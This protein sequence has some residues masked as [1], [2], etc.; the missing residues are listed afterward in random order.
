MFSRLTINA[1]SRISAPG[2]ESGGL[3]VV[4]AQ[5]GTFRI[6]ASA[7]L[8]PTF[9][10]VVDNGVIGCAD[11]E[12]PATEQTHTAAALLRRSEGALGFS[13]LFFAASCR[14]GWLATPARRLATSWSASW[15]KR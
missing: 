10:G 11:E 2:W 5:H 8:A 15:P 7:S 12:D 14:V 9:A 1:I 13:Y 3:A 4:D 6:Q